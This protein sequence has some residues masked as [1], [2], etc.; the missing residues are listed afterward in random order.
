MSDPASVESIADYLIAKSDA[1]SNLK[2]QKLLY[3]AQGWYLGLHSKPLFEARIEAWV[4]GPVVPPIFQKYRV[5]GWK[6]IPSH[7]SLPEISAAAAK[8]IDQVLRAYGRYTG[9]QLERLSHSEKPWLDA[10]NGIPDDVPST[11]EITKESMREF[12][13]KRP[14]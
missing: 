1:I 13:G 9:T 2:L 11:A 8:H 6:N 10:R 12:F 3:Y 5:Y 14:S 7:N 4:H